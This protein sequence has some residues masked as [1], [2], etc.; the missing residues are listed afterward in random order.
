MVEQTDVSLAMDL[1]DITL[2]GCS[3]SA[4]A[5]IQGREL[6]RQL[7]VNNPAKQFTVDVKRRRNV[8]RAMVDIQFGLFDNREKEN[9]PEHGLQQLQVFHFGLAVGVVV[10]APIMGE[11]AIA[12]RHLA[13][14]K[15]PKEYRDENIE[16]AMRIEAIK[17]AYGMATSKLVELSS[18]SPV[19][20]L[21]LPLID[22]DEILD[23]I[24]RREGAGA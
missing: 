21:V 3:F 7:V 18:M 15:D 6:N 16:R 1:E 22:T 12:P 24:A 5:P 10:T 4:E 9:I 23:D 13:S 14:S 19:G 17:A 8:L 20:T 11:D 2:L